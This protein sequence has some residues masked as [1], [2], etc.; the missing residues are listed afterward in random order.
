M[1]DDTSKPTRWVPIEMTGI[2]GLYVPLMGGF[3]RFV[4]PA[5]VPAARMAL[6]QAR[7]AWLN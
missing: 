4:E 1:A 2:K 7:K 6:E 5:D 3:V